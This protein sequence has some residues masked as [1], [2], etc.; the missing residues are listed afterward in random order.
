[1]PAEAALEGGGIKGGEGSR[2][3]PGGGGGQEPRAI[4]MQGGGS[5]LHAPLS[6]QSFSGSFVH[7]PVLRL[8]LENSSCRVSGGGT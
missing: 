4:E 6:P 3:A 5:L 2:A 7:W 1:M 8:S